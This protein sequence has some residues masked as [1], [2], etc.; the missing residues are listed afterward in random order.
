[1][2]LGKRHFATLISM[3]VILGT[4]LSAC[5]LGPQ[6]RAASDVSGTTPMGTP[7]KTVGGV[8]GAQAAEPQAT[9]GVDE[10]NAEALD[11]GL[12][13]ARGVVEDPLQ[14]DLDHEPY[15][16]EGREEARLVVEGPLLPRVL[17]HQLADEPAGRGRHHQRRDGE[18]AGP[19][20]F[21]EA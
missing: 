12:A 2:I 18:Q 15:S 1:M 16:L 11:V 20:R 21:V 19:A 14:Q 3:L 8:P 7:G 6:T 13:A 17:A 9:A 5:Q 10:R 4:A